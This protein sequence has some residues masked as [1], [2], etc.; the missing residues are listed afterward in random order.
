MQAYL[1]SPDVHIETFEEQAVLFVEAEDRLVTINAAS[2]DLFRKIRTHFSETSF[3]FD[4]AVTF[5]CSSFQI[6]PVDAADQARRLLIFG[7]RQGLVCKTPIKRD[8]DE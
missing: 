3:N 1:L 8:P 5:L 2:T 6:S 4:E 7:L